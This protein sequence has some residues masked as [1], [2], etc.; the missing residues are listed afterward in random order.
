MFALD[1]IHTECWAPRRGGAVVSLWRHGRPTAGRI[2]QMLA[3]APGRTNHERIERIG[4]WEKII[5]WAQAHQY[6][7][8]ARFVDDA[9]AEAAADRRGFTVEDAIASAEAEIALVLHTTTRTAGCR[10]DDARELRHRFPATMTALLDGRITLSQARAIVDGGIDLNDEQALALEQQVIRRAGRQTL[11]QL[12]ESVRRAATNV[13][14]EAA[15]RRHQRKRRERK[16]VLYPER[17]GMAT[18][19]ATLPATEA[20]GVYAVLDQHARACGGGDQ[21]AMD[22]RRADTLVDL[23][24]GETGFLSAG[25][26]GSGAGPADDESRSSADNNAR[27]QRRPDRRR[28]GCR[29]PGCRR[30]GCR[31]QGCQRQG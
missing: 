4:A 21:R 26:V 11:G 23:V 22:A 7:E 31:R 29:R 12:R 27:Q 30:Q 5:A 14:P 19:A 13:D 28:Q 17:D 2:G 20:V 6:D 1:L 25:T 9:A 10:A 15:E 8:I 18:L 16:V 24:L 3:A